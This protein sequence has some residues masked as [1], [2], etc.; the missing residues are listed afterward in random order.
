MNC[1]LFYVRL[2]RTNGGSRRPAMSKAARL[3]TGHVR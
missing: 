3:D 1:W 2:A